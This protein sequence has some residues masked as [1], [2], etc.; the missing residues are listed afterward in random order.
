MQAESDITPKRATT[1]TAITGFLRGV[2]TRQE[3]AI[4]LPFVAISLFFYSRNH[5]MLS[6]LFISSLLRT[7]A[8][9]GLI[10]MGMVMLMI[11]GEIDLSTERVMSFSAVAAAWLMKMAGWPIWLSVVAALVGALLIGAINAWLT[12]KM[13]V[14]SIISTIAVGFAV[15]GL[16]YLPT[17]G[18]PIYPLP[19]GVAYL[20]NL[21]PL[22]VSFGF[23]LMIG[24]MVVI[25]LILNGTRWGN[26]VFATGGNRQAAEI[27]GINTARVKTVCFMLTSLLAGVSGLLVMSGLPL[28]PGDP[29]IGKDLSLNIIAGV[30]LGGVSFYGGRGTAIG[31]LFGV[32]MM[33][34]IRSGLVVAHFDMYYQFPVLGAFMVL[35]ASVDI[36]RHRRREG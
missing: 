30:I 9:P 6:P 28:T 21:R 11:S 27:C 13:G 29:V 17:N 7:M 16:S 10:A 31:T 34:V 1:G 32:V 15:H 24:L 25:Q 18:L 19:A 26:M 20:G 12:V 14:N 4:I 22:G 36:I 3:T 23:W 5:A 35:A 8:Y 33:Q 2:L